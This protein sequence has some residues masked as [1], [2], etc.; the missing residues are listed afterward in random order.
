M[1]DDF[2]ISFSSRTVERQF[3]ESE[4]SSLFS[5]GSALEI[6]VLVAMTVQR[7]NG[8]LTKKVLPDAQNRGLLPSAEFF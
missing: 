4:E 8:S 5:A 7:I 3:P 1:S 6:I 2:S